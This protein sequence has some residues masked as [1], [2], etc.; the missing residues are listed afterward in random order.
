[1]TWAIYFSIA[2]LSQ[3]VFIPLYPY[4]ANLTDM[5][6]QSCIFKTAEYLRS[7]SRKNNNHILKLRTYFALFIPFQQSSWGKILLFPATWGFVHIIF[8][9]CTQKFLVFLIFFLILCTKRSIL[10]PAAVVGRT[11]FSR[12]PNFKVSKFSSCL[13]SLLPRRGCP[14]CLKS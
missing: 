9:S 4:V 14:H 8:E 11:A 7:R 1:M 10:V 5:I 12:C 6:I 3:F 2:V 13:A